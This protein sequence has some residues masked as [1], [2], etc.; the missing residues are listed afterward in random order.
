MSL[1][2]MMQQYHDAKQA[3]GDALLLFRMGDFYEL[4]F[5]DAKTAARE[6][7]LSL[8]TRD[9]GENPVP[10][11]G[12]PHHQLD[13]YLAKIISR[14]F[15]AAVCEQVEDPRHAKGI[16]KRD[17]TRIVS[18][19]TVTD[20]ALLEPC[21]ANFLLAIATAHPFAA[22]GLAWI[23]IS[24]GSF[25]AAVVAQERLGDE[26]ARIAPVE[27]LIR[28]DADELPAEWTEGRM[29]TRR[30]PWA[31]SREAAAESLARHFAAHSLEG[32]G[33]A[34]DD[35]PAIQAAGAVLDY[36]TETQKSSL[37]HIDRLVPYRRETRLEI[38]Q[39]TRRS[40]EICQTIRDG[41]REGSLLG[42]MDRTVTSMGARLLGQWIA[43]PLTD[44][45]AIDARLDAVS[46]L[47]ADAAFTADLCESLRSIYDVERLL[48]R[49]TT[50]RA[51]PRDLSFVGRTLR[52]LPKVKAKLAGRKAARLTQL[53][54][55]I[56]L[57]ADVRGKLEAALAEECP[58]NARDGGFI[59][60]GFRTDLD[61]QR[62]LAKGGKQW[63]A[64]YQVEAVQRTGINSMKVGFNNVFGYYLEVTHAQR[65]KVP[66]D[67]IRKQTLKNAE[68]Y[69]TPELK[70]HEEKV[71]AAEEKSKDIEYDLFIELRETVAAAA[72]R[73]LATAE[74]LAEI[75]VLAG[76][77]EL[78]RSRNYVR[79][80]MVAEPV[81]EIVAGRHPVLDATEPQGTFV[82]NDVRCAGNAEWGMENG[83]LK[84]SDGD[85]E[86]SPFP[87]PHS[88]IL[89]ITGP[90][91]AGKS[92]Y[93][94][95]AALLTLMAQ[96]GSFVP[97]QA[98]TI[99][100][101]DR[102]FARI[103]AS[104][105]LARGRSTFMVEMTETARILNTATPRSLVIL[106][107]IGRGTSTYDGLSLAWAVVE[108]L[109][110]TLG[111]RTLFAT[112]YHELTRLAEQ[113][114]ALANYNVAVREWQGEVIFLHQI[115]PG[116]ADKSYGIHV[117]Q[118][119]GVPRE[120]NRRA[121]ELLAGLEAAST[122]T[123]HE[124][125][126]GIAVNG[127]ATRRID[128]GR[129]G[130]GANGHLQLTLFEVAEHPLLEVIRNLDLDE[131][132][133]REAMERIRQ[134]QEQ[135]AAESGGRVPAAS[136]SGR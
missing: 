96:V 110:D 23:D 53:E 67:F 11:A 29:I 83:E 128:R 12:F 60:T 79:P 95:Q 89:L 43:A 10:M 136:E 100:V 33:F 109:H 86:H 57:C 94:R 111:C 32:F 66:A 64:A 112:H 115:I 85:S 71:L 134:W 129:R 58:L 61:V 27:I 56:D 114:P 77:A 121:S 98:A 30:P 92:T 80:T 15:R 72:R 122:P 75:D 28:D 106:D 51:T 48:A 107:E 125:S 39:A 16:V 41:R 26:L 118:M 123:A 21:A 108:H 103:G 101:A 42:V 2:P 87:I 105:D 104:D 120:V 20:D 46:E 17:V 25:E 84:R 127:A 54:E 76:L 38:D 132:S 73:I 44:V 119:A 93:I 113:L 19:G 63:I 22:C 9:K 65:D 8:T 62:E 102:I 59:R 69:V 1:T 133:P 68:R 82:P 40:L 116:A 131:T 135:L 88:A 91:M 5:E 50:G 78:A 35:G 34:D 97:A 52:C 45:A 4:F 31:F 18:R 24:T 13:Q 37:A 126:P 117:A 47:H 124:E 99:G 81:L 55:R 6:L 3:A 14:G 130:G 70:E 49:V 90:N 36:L 7:G 74:A